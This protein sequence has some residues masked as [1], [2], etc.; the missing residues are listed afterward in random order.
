MLIVKVIVQESSNKFCFSAEIE[1][2]QALKVSKG[3]FYLLLITYRPTVSTALFGKYF[4][5][6]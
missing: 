4:T 3:V 6:L 5:A 1:V 2:N